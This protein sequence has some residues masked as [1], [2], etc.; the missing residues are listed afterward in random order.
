VAS[1]DPDLDALTHVST[2]GGEGAEGVAH[3]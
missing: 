1:L 2:G 3:D